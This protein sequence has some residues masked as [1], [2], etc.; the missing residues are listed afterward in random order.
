MN[1]LINDP[2]ITPDELIQFEERIRENGKLAESKSYRYLYLIVV[3]STL[4]FLIKSTAINKL[5]FFSAEI[6]ELNP[7]LLMLPPVVAFF[8]YQYALNASYISLINALL[9]EYYSKVHKPIEERNLIEFTFDPN[10][11]NIEWT[12][13]NLMDKDTLFVKFGKIWTSNLIKIYAVLPILLLIWM[14][15]QML[16]LPIL[17][18]WWPIVSSILVLL[19]MVRGVWVLMMPSD[20]CHIPQSHND[21]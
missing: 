5:I 19:F 12:F 13:L 8:Y 20:L 21:I 11:L 6:E 10:F 16:S 14:S 3:T 1:E 2:D 18:D 9:F 7:L 17:G 4:W 15:Y